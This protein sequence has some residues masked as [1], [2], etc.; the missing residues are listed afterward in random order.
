[1]D[2]VWRRRLDQERRLGNLTAS[3]ELVLVAIGRD[4]VLGY[5]EPSEARLMSEAGVSRST[6]QRAKTRGRQLGLLEWERRF[7]WDGGRRV[8]RPCTYRTITPAT[9]PQKRERQPEARTESTIQRS[10]EAQLRALP[11]P[12]QAQ[13]K[14]WEDRKAKAGLWKSALC[15]APL[16]PVME[17]RS[18][19]FG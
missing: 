5:P 16:P 9:A 11:T 13:I 2:A 19:P 4:L 10:V 15:G 8:E 7:A 14:L 12:T 6:V 3:H 17:E 18:T 1:M